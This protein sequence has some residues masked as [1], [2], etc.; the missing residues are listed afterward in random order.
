MLKALL[1]DLDGT[2]V[3]NDPLHF[4]AWRY[5][6]ANHNVR[7]DEH[8]YYSRIS[9]RRNPEIVA[10]LLPHLAAEDARRVID[11]KESHYRTLITDL[12]PPPGLLRV[13]GWAAEQNLKLAIVTNAPRQNVNS[14]LQRL[15]LETQFVQI[16]SAEEIVAAKPD[17][18]PYRIALDC[19]GISAQQALAFEDSP[20]GIRSS[21]GAG[22]ETVGIASTQMPETLRQAGASLVVRDFSDPALW[23]L[24]QNA[25]AH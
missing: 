16:V 15:S 2:L 21:A 23:I 18:M 17:P 13:V 8:F 14:V 6:L 3:H 22:I 9:G 10:D 11:D 25:I 19:F 20:S 7:I 24:L 1:F 5:L 12:S 4:Q